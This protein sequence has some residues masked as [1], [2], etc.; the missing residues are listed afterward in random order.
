LQSKKLK[1]FEF[2]AVFF[3]RNESRVDVNG[4]ISQCKSSNN[5]FYSQIFQDFADE[6][7]H[8]LSKKMV[9]E[10]DEPNVNRESRVDYATFQV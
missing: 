10:G 7:D 6:L 3:R 2:P 5:L 9:G 1:I 8:A 4:Q